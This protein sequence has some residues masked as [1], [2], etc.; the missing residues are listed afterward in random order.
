M[1][2]K[3]LEPRTEKVDDFLKKFVYE[4]N[5]PLLRSTCEH[6]LFPAGKRIRAG[7]T[8]LACEAVGGKIKEVIPSAAAIEL[9]HNASLVYDDILSEN[10]TRRNKPSVY[11]LYGKNLGLIVGETLHSGAFKSVIS[12]MDIEG[13]DYLRVHNVLKTIT[14]YSLEVCNGVATQINR[15]FSITKILKEFKTNNTRSIKQHF[16]EKEYLDIIMGRTGVLV[17]TASKVGAIMGRGNSSEIES[18]WKYGIF[19]G[20]GY[21]VIDDLLD[22][23][24][25]KDDFGKPIGRDI[26]AGDLNFIIAYALENTDAKALEQILNVWGNKQASDED[27]TNTIGIL[28]DCGSIEYAKRKAEELIEQGIR[29]LDNIKDS[30]QKKIMKKFTLNMGL[31]LGGA[32]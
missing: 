2:L 13:M 1:R 29:E 21:Q 24:A 5:S 17:G 10:N 19:V 25:T 28:I 8:C 4:I 15:S 14:D 31:K 16:T 3:E 22:V 23:I 26:K 20:T 30:E 9:L 11:A 6:A 32:L 12:T 27:I 18:L 7:I